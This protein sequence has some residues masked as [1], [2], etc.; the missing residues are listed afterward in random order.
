MIEYRVWDE[1]GDLIYSGPFRETAE[2][3]MRA[4]INVHRIADE[5]EGCGVL[6][7]EADHGIHI[8]VCEDDRDVTGEQY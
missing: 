2:V 4:A 8:Q 6:T 5:C 1:S 7:P 3:E